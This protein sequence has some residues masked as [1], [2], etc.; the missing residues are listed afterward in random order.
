[1]RLPGGASCANDAFDQELWESFVTTTLL[2]GLVLAGHGK[3]G[4][5]GREREIRVASVRAGWLTAGKR[6]KQGEREG[7][8]ERETRVASTCSR[9]RIVVV[10]RVKH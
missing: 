2:K 5:A 4:S 3:S 7:W 10:E 8:R 9:A 6:E 1:M